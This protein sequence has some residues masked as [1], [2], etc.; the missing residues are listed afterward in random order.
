MKKFKSIYFLYVFF[1]FLNSCSSLSDAGKVLRNEK[2]GTTDEFL[3]KKKE[4]LSL[5]PKHSEIPTPDTLNKKEK[6]NKNNINEIFKI[7]E[8][9]SSEKKASS[10]EEKILI[11]IGRWLNE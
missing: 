6:R 7:E 1:I 8:N 9:N 3:V 5:P 4:P 10:I 11:Q 2:T